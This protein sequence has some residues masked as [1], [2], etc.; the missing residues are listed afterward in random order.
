MV[1]LKNV[2]KKFGSVKALDDVSLIFQ[3]GKITGLL[4]PNGSGK[5]T[6]LKLI[7]GLNKPSQGSVKVSGLSVSDET[8]KTISYLPEIDHFYPW[9]KV[10][11][12]KKFIST[13]FADWDEKKYKELLSFLELDES[14]QIRK[15]S[16]GQRAKVKLLL[17]F[18]RN[19]DIILLD[20]PLSGIDIFTREKIIETMIKDYREGEQS[21][22]IT[23]HEIKEIEHILDEAVFLKKGKIALTGSVEEMKE[24][25]GLSLVEIMKEVYQDGKEFY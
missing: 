1:E 11:D 10:I 8:K 18:S 7:C 23:T 5:S 19:A 22:I 6:M 13:M 14:M 25:K 24:E 15:I 2:S 20:E 3:K 12:A 16:K 9:M 17:S 4:G 21:I